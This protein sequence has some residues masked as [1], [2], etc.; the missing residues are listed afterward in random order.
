MACRKRQTD[1]TKHSTAFNNYE[2][3]TGYI[4]VNKFKKIFVQLRENFNLKVYNFKEQNTYRYTTPEKTTVALSYLQNKKIIYLFFQ[5]KETNNF[6]GYGSPK[7][8]MHCIF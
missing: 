7:S 4:G 8:S 2:A 5:K 6:Y 3:N 1:A